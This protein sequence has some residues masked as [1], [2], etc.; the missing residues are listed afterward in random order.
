MNYSKFK[1]S[2]SIV[3]TQQNA[4]KNFYLGVRP[5]IMKPL[6]TI[7]KKY[8]YNKNSKIDNYRLRIEFMENSVQFLITPDVPND[9]LIIEIQL[10]KIDFF[11]EKHFFS[12]RER[13]EIEEETIYNR[14]FTVNLKQIM[15]LIQMDHHNYECILFDFNN[16]GNLLNF[17]T[18]IS[19]RSQYWLKNGINFFNDEYI[20]INEFLGEILFTKKFNV[21]PFF[22]II[23]L[24]ENIEEG[25]FYKIFFEV[26]KEE[27][28]L[29]IVV[30]NYSKIE[31]GNED[32]KFLIEKFCNGSDLEEGQGDNVNNNYNDNDNLNEN[33][34]ENKTIF[35]E[36]LFNLFPIGKDKVLY[37]WEKFS[38]IFDLFKS[39][40]YKGGKIINQKVSFTLYDNYSILFD[41]EFMEKKIKAKTILYPIYNDNVGEFSDDDDFIKMNNENDYD[42][43]E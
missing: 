35:F 36:N 6:D 22:D 31:Y 40:V 38:E 30:R 13:N 2:T 17:K 27:N 21:S 8:T 20:L 42:D 24:H 18:V 11:L 4:I 23:E 43:I 1:S 28:S 16:Y 9:F 5:K 32:I 14:R 33:L 7:I 39:G 10:D 15:E 29:F 37:S 3:N 19:D 26:N 25:G 12:E 34:N 41:F